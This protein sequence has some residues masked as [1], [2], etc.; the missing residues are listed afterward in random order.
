MASSALHEL[1]F[2]YLSSLYPLVY[3]SQMCWIIFRL[4]VQLYFQ[5]LHKL[6]SVN[7][8]FS[9]SYLPLNPQLPLPNPTPHILSLVN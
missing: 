4:Q 2:A 1:V 7:L 5:G 6:Y 9:H 3:L 8:E